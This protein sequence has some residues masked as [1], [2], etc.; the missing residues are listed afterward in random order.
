M[1]MV[2]SNFY[3]DEQEDIESL[4]LDDSK[5]DL[6]GIEGGGVGCSTM[7]VFFSKKSLFCLTPHMDRGMFETCFTTEKVNLK[8]KQ[9]SFC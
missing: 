6:K 9:K 2:E 3:A 5:Q 4:Q 1:T 8:R 7:T